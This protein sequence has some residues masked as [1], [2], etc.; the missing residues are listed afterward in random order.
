MNA[1]KDGK[2]RKEIRTIVISSTGQ[3]N[4]NA[5]SRQSTVDSNDKYN[6]YFA[7]HTL[8]IF[9]PTHRVPNLLPTI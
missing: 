3:R 4:Q 7:P 2:S 5:D 9:T 6:I 8:L 1:Y